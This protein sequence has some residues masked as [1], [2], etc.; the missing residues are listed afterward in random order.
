ML[1]SGFAEVISLGAVIP[2]LGILTAPEQVFEYPVVASVAGFLGIASADEMVMPLTA[3][4]VMAVVTAGASRL[5]LL[6]ANIRFSN[7]CGA[8]LSIEVY[9]RTLYQPYSMHVIRNSSD[10]LGGIKK[11][12]SAQTVLQCMLTVVTSSVL[13]TSIL[14]ALLSINA[15]VAMVAAFGFGFSYLVIVKLTRWRLERNGKR[16]ARETTQMIKALQ[17]G[18][19]GIRDVLLDGSQ[20]LY[21]KIYSD[22]LMPATWASASSQFMGVS[23][24][25][26]MEVLGMVLIAGLAFSLS[27]EEGGLVSAMPLLAA[28]ALGAQRM[29]PAFQQLY[30]SWAAITGS[31]A[32]LADAL[33]LLDQP[34]PDDAS[35]PEPKPLDFKRDIHF[36]EVRFRYK[37][38][39]PWVLDGLNLDLP[40]GARIGFVGGTGGGKSTLLD[41]LMGLLEP[42]EGQILV[43]GVPIRSEHRRSWQKAIA[44]VPQAIY[45]ADTTIAENIALGVPSED[46]D[47]DRV[48]LA[49]QQAQIADF[50]E[51]IPDAYRSHVGE[52][53]VRLSGGQRQRIGIARA[54]YKRARVLVFDEA[55]SALDNAT[56]QAIVDSMA[57]LDRNLTVLLVAHR[58]TTVRHC[59][60]IIELQHGRVVAQGTFEQLLDS[61]PSFRNMVKSVA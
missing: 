3:G 7:A 42:V 28:L 22:S 45:L 16:V 6:W 26:I 8:D 58:L 11:V 23:P 44:H 52:R 19:G 33:D 38:D 12:S 34:L 31:R 35:S 41:L 60:I 20:S 32:S 59:D 24:R 18:L 37:D 53:G 55:T 21:C 29:L 48:K 10:I 54:L 43:D 25:Y 1:I 46:I 15:E 61:S 40:K 57:S 13:V 14:L 50:I 51:A 39:S 27:F 2:F 5:L 49:A 9:R 47:Y 56:E 36:D 17:E 4:F 30:A